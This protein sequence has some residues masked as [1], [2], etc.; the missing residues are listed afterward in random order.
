MEQKEKVFAYPCSSVF[1]RGQ[2]ALGFVAFDSGGGCQRPNA[3]GTVL[4]GRTLRY[5][6]LRGLLR[7]RENARFDSGLGGEATVSD[8]SRFLLPRQAF[9]KLPGAISK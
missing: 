4:A 1:I 2:Y 6:P 7:S 3:A 9:G 5:E 8:D